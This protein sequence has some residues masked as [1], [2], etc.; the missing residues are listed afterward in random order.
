MDKTIEHKFFEPFTS[1]GIVADCIFYVAR[2][3]DL[4]HTPTIKK[5]IDGIVCNVLC[6]L[7]TDLERHKCRLIDNF[8]ALK[9]DFWAAYGKDN[10][11][12]YEIEANLHEYKTATQK[13]N[14]IHS[15]IVPFGGVGCG[16]AEILAPSSTQASTDESDNNTVLATFKQIAAGLYIENGKPKR[17]NNGTVEYCLHV[18][19]GIMRNFANGLDALLLAEGIDLLRLQDEIGVRLIEQHDKSALKRYLTDEQ[20]AR[21][22][23]AVTSQP[24][25]GEPQQDGTSTPAVKKAGKKGRPAETSSF[26][27][28]LIADE[29]GE[30]LKRLHDAADKIKGK[31]AKMFW[32]YILAAIDLGWLK[33]LPAYKTLKDEF[34]EIGAKSSYSRWTNK[35]NYENKYTQKEIEE[36]KSILTGTVL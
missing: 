30:K 26:K 22:I 6:R 5:I 35:N 18:F 16:L 10:P 21:Y 29:S 8:K 32:V 19:I 1:G 11:L 9:Y 2:K 4:P 33:D 36:A 13:V 20:L 27:D 12:F 23:D 17:Y 15:L 28:L 24:A 25:S 34:G 3:Y 14:Y 31:K 7:N